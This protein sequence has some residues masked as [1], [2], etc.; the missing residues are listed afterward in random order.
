M[1]D[2]ELA[3]LLNNS[4]TMNIKNRNFETAIPMLRQ[5]MALEPGSAMITTNLGCAYW[6]LLDFETARK[7]F[8]DAMTIDPDHASAYANMGLMLASDNRFDAAQQMFERAINLDPQNASYRWDE[9]ITKLDMG[10][11]RD[12]FKDYSIRFDYKAEDYKVLP[13]PQYT[14]GDLRGKTLFVVAEQGIGDRI[15]FSRFLVE[16]KKKYPGMRLL[17]MTEQITWPLFWNMKLRGVIDELIPLN[18]PYPKADFA[19]YQMDLAG[20]LGLERDNIPPC[21]DYLKEYANI[22]GKGTTKTTRKSN[23]IGIAWRGNSEFLLN[24]WRSTELKQWL[25]LFDNPNVTWFSLQIDGT[26]DIKKLGLDCMI[27][28]CA[29]KLKAGGWNQTIQIVSS[30]DLVISVDTAVAHLA[31]ALGVPC[32]LL[33]HKANFWPYGRIHTNEWYSKQEYIKQ[34]R[35]GDWAGVFDDVR[36]RID[37]LSVPQN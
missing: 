10:E 11:W 21:Y 27:Y 23:K 33:L 22:I 35:V 7:Y 31:G 36:T 13:Y 8:R 3:E 1:E 18:V 14:G 25:C 34:T 15:M 9:M 4:A 26:D 32:W 17:F 19:I 30:L 20:A 2:K 29:D 37:R 28:D 6:N 5:A 12:G 24:H 16:L